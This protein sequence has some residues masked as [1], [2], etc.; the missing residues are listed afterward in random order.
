MNYIQI[1][2]THDNVCEIIHKKCHHKT[3]IMTLKKYE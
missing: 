1:S 2:T 3:Y